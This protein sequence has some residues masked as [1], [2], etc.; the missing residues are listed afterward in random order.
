MKLRVLDV[1][2]SWERMP[3]VTSLFGGTVPAA[4]L[5][6]SPERGPRPAN[7]ASR[8]RKRAVGPF[9]PSRH[10]RETDCTLAHHTHPAHARRGPDF[11]AHPPSR[12]ELTNAYR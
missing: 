1:E 12:V 3:A 7:R 8:M 10:P 2:C 4:Q 5:T 6:S 9:T 11:S